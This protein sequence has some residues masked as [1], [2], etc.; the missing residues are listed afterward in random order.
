MSSAPSIATLAR[1]LALAMVVAGLGGCGGTSRPIDDDAA[2]SS[3]DTGPSSSS[4]SPPSDGPPAPDPSAPADESTGP[5]LPPDGSTGGANA[6]GDDEAT[7]GG[8]T[9]DDGVSDDTTTGAA[10]QGWCAWTCI[11]DAECPNEGGLQPELACIDGFCQYADFPQCDPDLCENELGMVCRVV[12]GLDS[13]VLP[14]T[15]GGSECSALGFECNLFDDSG[16]PVCGPL[17]CW[18]AIEGA[19]CML[20]WGNFGTCVAGECICFGDAECTVPGTGCNN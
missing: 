8:A 13:C 9:L 17:P 11:S 10:Q 19:P 4:A 12:E 5:D 20:P 3:E 15:L 6:S 1:S 14:C 2:G 7:A 18:G 16:H